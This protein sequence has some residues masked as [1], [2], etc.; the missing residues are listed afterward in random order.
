MFRPSGLFKAVGCPQI[1]TCSLQNCLFSHTVEA[2][3]PARPLTANVP[4]SSHA[5]DSPAVSAKDSSKERSV[6]PPPPKRRRI[7]DDSASTMSKPPIK[8]ILK[9]P[10]NG[11]ATAAVVHNLPANSMPRSNPSDSS[12]DDD[13]GRY[14]KMVTTDNRTG[15][16]TKSRLDRIIGSSR[17]TPPT[18]ATAS[19]SG[20]SHG[21]PVNAATSDHRAGPKTTAQI[22]KAS[23]SKNMLRPNTAVATTSTSTSLPPRGARAFHSTAD[24]QNTLA[25]R[26]ATTATT[27]PTPIALGSTQPATDAP[28]ETLAPRPVPKQPV[29]WDQ[30]YKFVQELYKQYIR[31]DP[32]SKQRATKAAL[33]EE[34]AAA[35]KDSKAYP[36][37]MR[38][39]LYALLKMKPEDYAKELEEKRQAEAAEAAKE[40]GV[41]ATGLTPEDE[42]R[43][44]AGYVHSYSMLKLYDYIVIPPSDEEI[45]KAKEGVLA[46]NG[47]EECERCKSRFQILQ[48]KDP[49]TG[50]WTTNGKCVHHYGKAWATERGGPR[51][52]QC[53]QQVVG[54]TVGCTDGPTHV[55]MVKHPPRLA[56]LW[57]FMDTPAPT[58]TSTNTSTENQTTIEK[59]V[60]LDCEMAFTTEGFEMIRLTATR[61]PTFETVVDVLVQPFGEIL[62]LNTRFSGVTKE[63]WAAAPALKPGTV[64]GEKATI[65]PKAISP[66]HAREVLFKHVDATTI[67]IGH[68]LENDLKCMRI[69]HPRIVDTAILYPRRN[70]PARWSL[71]VLVKNHLG[72]YIQATDSDKGHDS[73]EDAN[74]AGNLVRKKLMNDVQSGKIGLDGIWA[75]AE[76]L[77]T[78][79]KAENMAPKAAA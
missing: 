5:P 8:S 26:T 75:V 43:A 68:S 4:A 31:L 62:D 14:V 9:K 37:T 78:P 32:S 77:D 27:T 46:A 72:R 29:P 22:D 16:K 34:E 40:A 76:A 12:F 69:I 1:A 35:I 56:S 3:S 2:P 42:T 65:T 44:I 54:E 50:L 21:Q 58:S 60:C 33:D 19:S 57:Q 64:Y 7:E 38:L 45:T 66:I 55:F 6:T 53:C 73:K 17:A 28:S 13:D 67:L 63:Q 36:V 30:R 74:E 51:I 47:E 48:H 70:M 25:S 39:R 79:L 15:V 11:A 61:F 10:S 23:L 49:E 24:K 52:W 20:S 18:V 41:I 59:A 71:K